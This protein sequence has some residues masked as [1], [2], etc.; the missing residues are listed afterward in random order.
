M[1][2]LN[3]FY[4]IVSLCHF[5]TLT[6]KRVVVE[7]LG[8]YPPRSSPLQR[9]PKEFI[10]RQS[11]VGFVRK[12][13]TIFSSQALSTFVLSTFILTTP[14]L[15]SYLLKHIRSVLS[16]TFLGSVVITAS[17]TNHPTLRFNFPANILM[18]MGYTILQ[19]ISVGAITAGYD[20]RI[21]CLGALHSLVVFVAMTLFSFQPNPR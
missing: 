11:R 17:L 9:S 15:S 2:V 6:A 14:Q 10:D 13:Y 5:T 19:S 4:L 3:A 7:Q 21:V 18:L 16:F 20:S 8:S 12:V 1:K